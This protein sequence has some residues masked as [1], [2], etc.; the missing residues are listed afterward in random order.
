MSPSGS[1]HPDADRI[2]MSMKPLSISLESDEVRTMKLEIF[3]HD[4][5]L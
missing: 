2:I 1:P 3:L 4:K 5:Y